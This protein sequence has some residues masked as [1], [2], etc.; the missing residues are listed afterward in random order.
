MADNKQINDE[1]VLLRKMRSLID[2]RLVQLEEQLKYRTV[3][4]VANSGSIYT[5]VEASSIKPYI[6][7]WVDQGHTLI[8]LADKAGL[9]ESVISKIL[10]DERATIR[11]STADSILT[12][13]GVSPHVYDGLVPEPPEGH[14]YEE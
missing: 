10:N 8:A 14:F 6:Q 11:T 13:L 1:I 3:L 5:G 7:E 2:E 9:S 12:A 4:R